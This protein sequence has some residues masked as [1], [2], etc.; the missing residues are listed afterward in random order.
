M[1]ADNQR[2]RDARATQAGG[3]GENRKVNEVGLMGEES[4]YI[5]Y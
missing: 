2:Q 4:I 1:A 3:R 5:E